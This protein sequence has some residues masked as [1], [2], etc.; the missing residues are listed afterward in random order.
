MGSSSPSPEPWEQP[1][2]AIEQQRTNVKARNAAGGISS[3]VRAGEG[4]LARETDT[5]KDEI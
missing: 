1:R 3:P 5:Q 4:E 2:A